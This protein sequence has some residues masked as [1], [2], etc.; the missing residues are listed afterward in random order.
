MS[1]TSLLVLFIACGNESTTTPVS[2]QPTPDIEATVEARVAA[3]IV[4]VQPTVVVRATPSPVPPKPTVVAR[5]KS[6]F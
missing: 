2:I 5:A 3:K 1:I 6:N 4:A